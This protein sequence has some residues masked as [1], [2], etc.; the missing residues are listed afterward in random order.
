[1]RG[2]LKIL[3]EE[4]EVVKIQQEVSTKYEAAKI[5]KEHDK[6]TVIF[7]NIEGHDMKIVS[8]ICNSREKIARSISSNIGDINKRMINATE[9][10]REIV[11]IE[12]IRDNY[13]ISKKPDLSEFP[14]LTYYQRD[15]GPYITAG[16]IIAK[17]PETNIPNASIHR[18]LVLGKNRLTA[19]LV[20]RHLYTYH[21]KAEEMDK[22]LEI[23]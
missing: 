7:E 10:P 14:I 13:E 23:A 8:G 18:M 1:M 21:Q 17:D 15:A 22:P 9:N 4:F 5:L 3:E 20:P 19:R 2:F 6:K 11:K 16:V 12:K